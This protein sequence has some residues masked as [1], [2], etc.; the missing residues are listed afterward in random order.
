MEALQPGGRWV[1]ASSHSIMNN[2]PHENFI[3]M[4]NA[5]HKYGSY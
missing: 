1:A 5:L 3:A 4:I 2:I